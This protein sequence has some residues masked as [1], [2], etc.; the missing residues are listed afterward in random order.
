[1]HDKIRALNSILEQLER[2]LAGFE[3]D[4]AGQRRDARRRAA[5]HRLCDAFRQHMTELTQSARRDGAQA[6]D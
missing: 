2:E 6:H 4:T 5:I 1:M 3:I